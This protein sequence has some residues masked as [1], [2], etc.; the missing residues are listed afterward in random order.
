M[1]EKGVVKYVRIG[2]SKGSFMFETTLGA[3]DSSTKANSV[4]QL[5]NLYFENDGRKRL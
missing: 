4:I 2:Y 1:K 3:M 5:V